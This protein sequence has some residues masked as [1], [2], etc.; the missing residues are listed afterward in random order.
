ML[1]EYDA[2]EIKQKV[3]QGTGFDPS[4]LSSEELKNAGMLP[5]VVVLPEKSR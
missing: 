3:Q 1:R 4:R 2:D 5:V